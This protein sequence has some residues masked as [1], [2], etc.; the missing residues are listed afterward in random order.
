MILLILIIGWWNSQTMNFVCSVQK[1]PLPFYFSEE[2][3]INIILQGSSQNFFLTEMKNLG[4]F[5]ELLLMG[6]PFK[7]KVWQD[8][9]NFVKWAMWFESFVFKK[10]TIGT[11][12]ILRCYSYYWFY[13][14]CSFRGWNNFLL[15]MRSLLC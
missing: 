3:Q 9:C 13:F 10:F 12:I 7:N 2:E 14:V 11:N 8:V 15:V 5:K 6:F 4:S 1:S